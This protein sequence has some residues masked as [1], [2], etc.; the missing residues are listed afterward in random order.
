MFAKARLLL[1]ALEL[2]RRMRLDAGRVGVNVSGAGAPP[3][4]EAVRG[5][6]SVAAM[7]SFGE[8]KG[9]G[10][11]GRLA[12]LPMTPGGSEAM[13]EA[14]PEAP[15]LEETRLVVERFDRVRFHGLGDA[16]GE[17]EPMTPGW[18][19]GLAAVLAVAEGHT[20]LAAE[21]NEA[22]A[23]EPR[24]GEVGRCVKAEGVPSVGVPA[25]DEAGEKDGLEGVQ[26]RDVE[27]ER[28]LA[29]RRTGDCVELAAK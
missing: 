17:P 28:M 9:D 13:G 16:R 4:D 23:L 11:A 2:G 25:R 29:G 14:T 18:G 6:N 19:L 10:E 22:N 8:P 15:P 21:V 27:K 20:G 12:E 1:L 24:C 7:L 5:L 3:E 26:G